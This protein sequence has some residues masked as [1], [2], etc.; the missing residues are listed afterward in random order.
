MLE[1]LSEIIAP[2]SRSEQV[3]SGT[4]TSEGVAVS[5]VRQ[6]HSAG[7]R[8]S[9][10]PQLTAN[11]RLGTVGGLGLTRYIEP[12]FVYRRI[13]LTSFLVCVL[14]GWAALLLWPRTYESTSKLQLL[15]GRESVGLDPSST[16]TQTLL[17]QKSMEE[18]VN[19]ALEILGSREVAELVVK[20][21]GFEAIMEGG[22]LGSGDGT[23][24]PRWKTALQKTKQHAGQ[25]TMKLVDMTGV[26]DSVS[27]HERAII[28]LQDTVSVHAPKKSSTMIVSAQSKSPEMAQAIVNAYVRHFIQRHVNVS[29]TAGSFGFFE[30]QAFATHNKLRDLMKQRSELLQQ[31]QLVSASNRFTSLTAQEATIETTVFSTEASIKQAVA[32][33]EDLL[34]RLEE[35]DQEI[36][37]TKQ[38]Q[39]DQTV[40]GMRIALYNAELEEK[41][42][43]ARYQPNHPRLRQMQQQVAAAREALDKL[44][45]DSESQST[46]PNPLRQRVEEDFLKTKTR[47]VGLESMLA[48]SRQQLER[49]RHEIHEL[50]DVELQL[51][52]LDREIEVARKNLIVLQEKEEQSRVVDKLRQQQISSIGIAQPATLA[53]KP[54]KPRKPL[55]AASA[56]LLGLGIGVGLV[57]LKEGN[58]Q[59][60]RSADDVQRLL[61]CPVLVEVPRN[62]RLA[63]QTLRADDWE[64]TAL[65]PLRRAADAL[66]AELLL[67]GD[68]ISD[69]SQRGRTV[70]LVGVHDGCGTSTIATAL[71][72][73][74]SELEQSRTIL[75][76]LDAGKQTVT[77]AFAVSAAVST[78]SAIDPASTPAHGGHAIARRSLRLYAPSSPVFKPSTVRGRTDWQAVLDEIA[79]DG[80]MVILDFPPVVRPE[81]SLAAIPQLDQILLIVEADKTTFDSAAKLLNHLQKNGGEV[82]GIVL[83]KSQRHVPRW[84][85][86]LLG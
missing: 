32:E 8:V 59:E 55:I 74:C 29:T 70:G 69:A 49:K 11:A 75:V 48:E 60:I 35:L 24:P 15:V 45:Q 82:A 2:R 7:E 44:E 22:L 23:V 56:L 65:R 1:P 76:D 41:R 53:T 57:F 71:A 62:R 77:D 42:M 17:M 33:L 10:A 47:V 85:E 63:K 43:L 84:L 6:E 83:M 79:V 66:Q 80:D 19:S 26:R 73:R 30:E 16:T 78:G 25:W 64:S 54:A 31:H 58:R 52:Q 40:S 34:E 5:A 39:P 67:A 86:K 18:D 4:V 20:E 81:P 12:F 46:S 13:V 14:G 21:L 50:L 3:S 37:A 27:D 28:R 72:M 51:E 38:T 68:G 61:G 36:V 9:A